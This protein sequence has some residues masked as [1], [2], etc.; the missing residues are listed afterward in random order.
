MHS[1]LILSRHAG[2]YHR[3]VSAAG[4]PD[5]EVTA[6]SDAADARARA[7][8]FDLAFGEPSLLKQV[9]PAMSRVRWVQATWAGVE[10]LLDPTLRRD[11][12]LTNARGVFGGLMSE[13]VFAYLLAHERRL[14]EKHKAQAE[15]RWDPR[16]PG[17]L[18]GKHLGLLGVG[19]IGAAL[20]RTARHFDMR[21]HGYTR[22]SEDSPDVDVY[23]HGAL[24]S[25]RHA[26]A[27]ELDYLVSIMPATRETRH[28]VDADLLERL[29]LA[30]QLALEFPVELIAHLGGAAMEVFGEFPLLGGM[31]RRLGRWASRR[32]C[33]E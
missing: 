22:V 31:G 28:V 24:A 10:P 30:R 29:G 20:A 19:T 32:A 4:L 6:T 21:V 17:T 3:L 13:Y 18:R 33:G 2:E 5:L 11:Y 1:L 14:L 16:P 15:G 27:G 23:F 8:D 12:T 7:A 26:F 9:L 25:Q